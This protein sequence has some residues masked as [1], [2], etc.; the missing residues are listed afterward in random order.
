MTVE[1]RPYREGDEPAIL[2]LFDLVFSRPLST[3]FWRWRQ[4]E[5]P[6]GGP[7]TELGWQGDKLVAHYAVSAQRLCVEGELVPSCLSMTTMVHPDNR[8]QSL[9][10]RSAEALYSRLTEKGVVAVFGFPNNNSHRPFVTKL[11]WRDIHEVPTLRLALASA[12]VPPADGVA[13]I[14]EFDDRFDRLWA[15]VATR[16]PFWFCRDKASLR[17]RFTHN[18]SATYR[19]GALEE[20]GE[21]RGYVVTKPYGDQS[22]D[23][24]DI[25]VEE[26]AMSSRLIGW[27]CGVAAGAK[28]PN[29][30]TWLS[31]DCRERP[32]FEQA[33]FV[34][35]APV[36]YFGGRAFKPLRGDGFDRRN[37]FYAM[38]DS[39]LY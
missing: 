8:G 10:E 32:H 26:P 31:V 14:T 25:M 28:L 20:D 11:G 4:R 5:N 17:W 35:T 39:D 24:V 19:I 38:A 36:T 29:L 7:W 27:A 18:P 15:R 13:E 16:H 9:F 34:C 2:D 30:S 37:W 23:L 12:K 22:L 3:Q 33:G 21:V 6:A 1:F